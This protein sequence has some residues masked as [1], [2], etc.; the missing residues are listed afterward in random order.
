MAAPTARARPRHLN[1]GL[2][3]HWAGAAG[4]GGVASGSGV[5]CFGS[6]PVLRER[7]GADRLRKGIGNRPGMGLGTGSEERARAPKPSR[8][9]GHV[10]F[11]AA[12]RSREWRS[13]R[14]PAVPHPPSPPR[15]AR[16]VPPP[17]PGP[18]RRGP[19]AARASPET[20]QPPSGWRRK[21]AAGGEGGLSVR[22]RL[23]H[24]NGR[25]YLAFSR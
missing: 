9:A 21:M 13:R 10:P 23:R 14:G 18:A 3:A 20:L 2:R 24:L 5:R 16:P 1:R 11:P 6:R 22:F 19:R 25:R 17:S 15:S 4:R 7:G 8:S 12:P